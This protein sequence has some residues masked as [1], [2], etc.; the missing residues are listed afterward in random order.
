MNFI[1]MTIPELSTEIEHIQDDLKSLSEEISFS[2]TRL[3]ILRDIL[4]TK[5]QEANR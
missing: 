2:I 1:Y 5:N 4:N 3:R